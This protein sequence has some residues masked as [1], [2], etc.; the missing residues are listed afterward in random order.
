ML[1]FSDEKVDGPCFLEL[2]ENDLKSFGL[3]LGIRKKV[4]TL[5][6]EVML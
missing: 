5:Q 3:P 2:T 6:K 1:S 4:H